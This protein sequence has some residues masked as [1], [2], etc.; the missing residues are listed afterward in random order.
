MKEKET[1]HKEYKKAISE[2]HG[3]YLMDQDEE[4]TVSIINTYGPIRTLH[5]LAKISNKVCC[6]KDNLSEI[7]LFLHI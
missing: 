7:T 5:Y 1:A 3:A 6:I 2:G 4:T